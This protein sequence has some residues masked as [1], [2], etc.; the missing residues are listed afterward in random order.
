MIIDVGILSQFVSMAGAGAAQ[1]FL[2]VDNGGKSC[3]CNRW[4]CSVCLTVDKKRLVSDRIGTLTSKRISKVSTDELICD[5]G[6]TRDEICEEVGF[7]DHVR[8]VC[9]GNGGEHWLGLV[10]R[11]GLLH[12]S[13]D[14]AKSL[15]RDDKAFVF[16]LFGPRREFVV[17]R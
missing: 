14:E 10:L 4:P 13:V 17:V 12:M 16:V 1:F 6:V 7:F 8:E 5:V 2:F 9:L 11:F 15:K 3:C